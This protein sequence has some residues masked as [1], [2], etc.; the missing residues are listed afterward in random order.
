MAKL[1]RTSYKDLD[2]RQWAV[3]VPAGVSD[4][5]AHMGLH[6][7]P[8]PLTELG[9][10]LETEVRLHNELF[11][12]GILTLTDAKKRRAEL[13]ASLQAAYAVD[14]ERLIELYAGANGNGNGNGNKEG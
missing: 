7:G 5:D 2:G 12:R 13:F 11:R 9:L 8:Q 3:D 14:S 6:V 1:R 10:P 4:K